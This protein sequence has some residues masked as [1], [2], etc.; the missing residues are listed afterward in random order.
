MAE[1]EAEQV[2]SKR[3]REEESQS[4]NQQPKRQKSYLSLLEAEE[5]E[6]PQDLSSH[7]VLDL[8][9]QPTLKADDQDNPATM[10]NSDSI[11]D[12][13]TP[14]CSLKGEQD[15]VIRHLLQASDD[16][17]GIPNTQADAD[18]HNAGN[19]FAFSDGLWELED[20]AANYYTLLQSQLFMLM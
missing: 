13:A 5:E 20:E 18:A 3:Q 8:P 6:S 1:A 14:T 15:D 9:F 17:L 7:S 19:A 2:G 11:Q 4:S 12:Y 16:E 10:T